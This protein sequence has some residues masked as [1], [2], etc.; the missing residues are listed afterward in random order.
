MNAV[1]KR[2]LFMKPPVKKAAGGIMSLVD[3]SPE[4]AE[5]NFSDRVPENPE[6]IANTLRGDM[7]SMDER[8]L[9]LAQMV[10]EQAFETP[11][12]VVVLMQSQLGAM[13]PQQQQPSAPAPS[14]Q[15]LAALAQ[16][17]GEQQPGQPG[18]PGQPQA[19]GGAPAQP[20]G[21]ESLVAGGEQPTQEQQ[22]APPTQAPV[23]RAMGSGP[24]GEMSAGMPM[25]MGSVPQT[26]NPVFDELESAAQNFEQSTGGDDLLLKIA[27][28]EIPEDLGERMLSPVRRQLGSG[29]MGERI[30]P[31]FRIDDT[32]NRGPTA[33]NQAAT[34]RNIP[35]WQRSLMAE[36]VLPETPDNTPKSRPL[37][38]EELE[39]RVRRGEREGP[40]KRRLYDFARSKGIDPNVAES[41]V[42]SFLRRPTVRAVTGAGSRVL[43]LANRIPGPVG[44][45]AAA[46]ALGLGYL[47]MLARESDQNVVKPND[48]VV[49]P[50]GGMAD[51]IPPVAGTPLGEN[52][53]AA[54]LVPGLK[55]D[56][57]PESA[58]ASPE[59]IRLKVLPEEKVEYPGVAEVIND[60]TLTPDYA[61]AMNAGQGESFAPSVPKK[62]E[63]ESDSDFAKRVKERAKVYGELLGDD[64]QMRKARAYFILA[65]AGLQLAGAKGNT[66]GERLQKGLEGVPSA[67]SQLVSER[68]KTQKAIM[69]SAISAVEQEDRDTAKYA[70]A[71]ANKLLELQKSGLARDQKISSIAQV[72][73]ASNPGMTPESAV[74]MAT[75]QADGAVVGD[76]LGNLRDPS[77]RIIAYGPANQPTQQGQTGFI[78]D[79]HPFIKLESS[80]L[81]PAQTEDEMIKLRDDRAGKARLLAGVQSLKSRLEDVY[82]PMNVIK[83][84]I[85]SVVTPIIG[86]IGPLDSS[87]QSAATAVRMFQKDLKELIAMNPERVSVYEQQQI[88]S[89]LDNPNSFFSSPD[90]ALGNLLEFERSLTNSINQ[91]DHRLNP[92]TPLKQL[93]RMPLGTK[94]DPIPGTA[95]SMLPEYFNARPTGTVYIQRPDGKVMGITKQQYEQGLK[96]Q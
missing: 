12:D 3:D 37:T 13:A 44:P 54:P 55:A 75:F 78:P 84:G 91:A 11:E 62:E 88:D 5:D 89:L 51:N 31:T 65:E 56:Q 24:M 15:G 59:P 68:E 36:G 40:F 42:K 48:G 93:S 7:R 57:G 74:R 85:T 60:Y 92:S 39:E 16:G 10:G 34:R 96:T 32:I 87:N 19:Q 95:V 27:S 50:V 25:S 82:G 67:F 86:D 38:P 8:Y 35:A 90:I 22:P 53:L 47:D 26:M 33:I 28:G 81:P 6:I 69:A 72:L 2:K 64:P 17:G 71:Y 43:S 41:R 94:N 73:R 20:G 21:I 23:Q 18:Q 52:R 49:P 46:G 1:L 30:E 76:K 77:G 14:P 58:S 66:F 61:Q 4:E 70:S 29:P 83:R 45:I 80:S 9:E 63:G 79:N